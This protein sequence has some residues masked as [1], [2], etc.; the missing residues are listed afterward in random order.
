VTTPPIGHFNV[1]LNCDGIL[2]VGPWA[3]TSWSILLAELVHGLAVRLDGRVQGGLVLVE[4]LL[5]RLLLSQLGVELGLERVQLV[6]GRNQ[7]RLLVIE[8]LPLSGN[9]VL[10]STLAL[11]AISTVWRISARVRWSSL[12]SSAR[13]LSA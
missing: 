10:S 4:L 3:A 6:L 7:L 5:G 12:I 9:L 8:L 11:L 13:A 2:P 1:P